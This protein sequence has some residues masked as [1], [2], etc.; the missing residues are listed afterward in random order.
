M[1]DDIIITQHYISTICIK[2]FIAISIENIDSI[3]I[4]A[5]GYKI[6]K[7]TSAIALLKI[8]ASRTIT[9][10]INTTVVG[11]HSGVTIIKVCC[12]RC[13]W[14]SKQHSACNC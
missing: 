10:I 3:F 5:N 9:R 2:L 6:R 8:H 4:P 7:S 11:Y 14:I 13:G 12:F 1:F